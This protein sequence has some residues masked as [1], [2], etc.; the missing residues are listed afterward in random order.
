M[1]LK[2][3]AILAAVLALVLA[4]CG[5]GSDSSGESGGGGGAVEVEAGDPV[6][7]ATVYKSTCAACHGPDLQGVDGLGKGLVPNEFVAT[8]TEEELANFINI[9][10]PAGDPANM[11]GVDMPP[12]GGNPSLTDQD[13]RDVSAYLKAQQ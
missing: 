8:S 9:G 4:A 12:R 1:T 10:R 11:T 3:L 13:I 7:G 2:R 5:G 6:N